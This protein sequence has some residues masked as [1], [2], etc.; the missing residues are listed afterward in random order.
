M[1]LGSGR[2]ISIGDLVK[3]IAGLTKRDVHIEEDHRRV[4]PDKSEV[5]RLLADSSQADK[6]LGWKPRVGLEEGLS[7]TIEWMRQNLTRYHSD[8]YA[9]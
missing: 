4:R 5:D 9:I 6:I 8:K 1:N 2:E 3:V 7:I